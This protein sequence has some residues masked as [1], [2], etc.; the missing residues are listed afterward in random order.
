MAAM[1]GVMRALVSAEANW[2]PNG[3]PMPIVG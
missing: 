3:M 2:G 1:N